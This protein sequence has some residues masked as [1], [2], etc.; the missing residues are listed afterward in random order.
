MSGIAGGAGITRNDDG[1]GRASS[2]S[3]ECR[4][5][6]DRGGL[7]T[8]PRHTFLTAKEVIARY[9]WGRTKG[10]QM[11]RQRG[12]PRSVGRDRYRLDALMAWEDRQLAQDEP[13]VAAVA[14][15][16]TLAFA[17]PPRKRPRRTATG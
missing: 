14:D 15:A 3:D 10:Y 7:A 8:D 1:L 13:P 9:G 6:G 12:F 4:E 5:R 2:V 11:L 16:G 17:F